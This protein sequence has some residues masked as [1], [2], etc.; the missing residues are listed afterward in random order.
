MQFVVRGYDGSDALPRRLAAREAHLALGDELVS[1][2]NLLY[3]AAILD[4]DGG[5]MIGSIL[6]V[7]FPSRQELDAWLAQEPYVVQNVW[8]KVDILP[9]RVGPAFQPTSAQ[10]T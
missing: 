8:E 2:G 5:T 4:E 1:T 7:D 6:V 3:A 9:C 10:V